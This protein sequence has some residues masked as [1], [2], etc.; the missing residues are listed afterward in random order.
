MCATS[1]VYPVFSVV[2]DSL[3]RKKK[4]AKEAS[5]PK[6]EKRL[7][8]RLLGLISCLTGSFNAAIFDFVQ[9]DA[10]KWFQFQSRGEP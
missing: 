2:P 9:I 6:R 8:K 1:L 4:K 7:L 3:K 10:L 5:F